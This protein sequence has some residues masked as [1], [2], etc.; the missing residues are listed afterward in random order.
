[1]HKK[2]G[3]DEELIVRFAKKGDIIGHRILSNDISY[4]VSAT[5]IEPVTTCFIDLDFL[6]HR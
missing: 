1:M 2:W 6:K 4:P 3:D 5:A